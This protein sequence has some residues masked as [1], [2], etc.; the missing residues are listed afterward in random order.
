MLAKAGE[1][2]ASPGKKCFAPVNTLPPSSHYRNNYHEQNMQNLQ[3]SHPF[4]WQP[5]KGLTNI[6]SLG[7]RRAGYIDVAFK[8]PPPFLNA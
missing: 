7:A 5:I 2:F 3:Y 6:Q 4:V 8:M 1:A